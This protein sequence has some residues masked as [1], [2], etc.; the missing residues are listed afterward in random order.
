MGPEQIVVRDGRRVLLGRLDFNDV[1]AGLGGE[2]AVS[3]FGGSGDVVPFRELGN[4]FGGG[5]WGRGVL[6]LVFQ[7]FGSR[8]SK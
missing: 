3:G 4:F 6:S 8:N 5:E 2:E 1:Q 7:F